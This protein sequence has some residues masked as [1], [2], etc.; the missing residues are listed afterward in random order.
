VAD[1]GLRG[2]YI[3]HVYDFYKPYFTSEYP[4]VDGHY[5]VSCYTKALDAVYRDYY[6]REAAQKACCSIANGPS[7]GNSSVLSN[8][9][10]SILPK[11]SLDRFDFLTFHA[12]TR[13]LVQKSYARLYTT[14]SS[15][16]PR[17]S[18]SQR[19]IVVVEQEKTKKRERKV[20]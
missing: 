12:P 10:N 2:T 18:G 4:Y 15:W 16:I 11:M 9:N 1:P 7:N 14:A 6:R 5:S 17:V 13:K 8:G 19:Q 3:Q 20:G